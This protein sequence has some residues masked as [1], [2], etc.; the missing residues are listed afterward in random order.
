MAASCVP[1]SATV[2]LIKIQN[3]STEKYW[4]PHKN[5]FI[6]WLACIRLLSVWFCES[7]DWLNASFIQTSVP[8][9]IKDLPWL[10]RTPCANKMWCW[11]WAQDL[12]CDGP[13]WVQYIQRLGRHS[14]VGSSLMA[15][16]HLKPP[17]LH[18]S[19][20]CLY[21]CKGLYPLHDDQDMGPCPKVKIN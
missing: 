10:L 2:I 17:D 4:I 16:G 20:F 13:W 14:P 6:S 8:P 5:C 7:A 19:S 18:Y 1:Q 11:S 12:S 3:K 21:S 15:C 9:Y